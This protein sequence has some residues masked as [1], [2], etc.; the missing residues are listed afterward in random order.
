MQSPIDEISNDEF[1]TSL[2]FR[3]FDTRTSQ[4]AIRNAARPAAT[5]LRRDR[6]SPGHSHLE[7]VHP[8][9]WHFGFESSARRKNM[10]SHKF[11]YNRC[12]PKFRIAV[13]LAI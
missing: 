1:N 8:G 4:F 3:S 2:R 6:A 7:A 10:T 12:S 13:V 5:H 9:F 11:R